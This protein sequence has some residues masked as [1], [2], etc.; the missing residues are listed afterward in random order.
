MGTLHYVEMVLGLARDK[1]LPPSELH[2]LC[3]SPPPPPSPAV[4][5]QG[6][7]RRGLS[8]LGADLHRAPSAHTLLLDLLFAAHYPH[9]VG[10]HRADW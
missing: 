7:Q 1:Q 8:A 10:E 5:H 2:V 6:W 3:A 9:P 4:T